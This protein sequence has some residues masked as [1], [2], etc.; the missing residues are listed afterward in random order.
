MDVTGATVT[1][2]TGATVT[3]ARAGYFM[4]KACSYVCQQNF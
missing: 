4:I 1:A 3:K 2:V